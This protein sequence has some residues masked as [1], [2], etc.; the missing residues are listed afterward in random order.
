MKLQEGYN[1]HRLKETSQAPEQSRFFFA[2]WKNKGIWQ[3]LKWFHDFK[4]NRQQL[5][6]A[7]L[8]TFSDLTGCLLVA[9]NL[10]RFRIF[11]L[12][13]IFLMITLGGQPDND[14]YETPE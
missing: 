2:I 10:C 14:R 11:F 1:Q 7:W 8:R 13:A 9:F 5:S 3:A 6:F 12:T 4:Q